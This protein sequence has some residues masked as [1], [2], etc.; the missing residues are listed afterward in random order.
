MGRK[1]KVM[2]KEMTR[3]FLNATAVTHGS[4]AGIYFRSCLAQG[5]VRIPEA[6]SIIVTVLADNYVDATRSDEKIAKRLKRV[7][8]PLDVAPHGEHGLP[9]RLKPSSTGNPTAAFRFRLDPRG[10]KHEALKVDPGKSKP[11]GSPRPLG[12]SAGF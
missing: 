8:S 9:T 1:E 3:E 2:D 11:L 10:R 6:D 12:S 7:V 4:S 5:V